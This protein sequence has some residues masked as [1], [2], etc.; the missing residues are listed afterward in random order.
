LAPTRAVVD[1][2]A[3]LHALLETFSESA[4]IEPRSTR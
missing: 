4:G 2:Q 3:K 1:V